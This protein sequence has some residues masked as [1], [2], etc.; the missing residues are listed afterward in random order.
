MAP[1]CGTER[2]SQARVDR[3]N[4]VLPTRPFLLRSQNGGN[5]HRR[6]CCRGV[7]LCR[8]GTPAAA[9]GQGQQHGGGHGHSKQGQRIEWPHDEEKRGDA[10]ERHRAYRYTL[11]IACTL[12]LRACATTQ[13]LTRTERNSRRA[14]DSLLHR[15]G[16]WCPSLSTENRHTCC[17]RRD[18]SQ[19][20]RPSLSGRSLNPWM[21]R[22]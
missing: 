15:R 18:C 3:P 12:Q 11:S 10:E 8:R 14:A 2:P 6:C 4:P 13:V 22:W 19:R 7:G 16:Q 21:P 1:W 5:G 9:T 20:I 17:Y